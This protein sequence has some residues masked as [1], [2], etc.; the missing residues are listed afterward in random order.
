M[1]AHEGTPKKGSKTGAARKAISQALFLESFAKS[2]NVRLAAG[3]AGISRRTHYKWLSL[4]ESDYAVAFKDA[5]DEA[6]DVLESEACRR[7]VEGVEEPVGWYKGEPGGFVRRY[8]D[9]LLMFLLKARRPEMYR[10][11]FERTERDVPRITEIRR[12]I[13]YPRERR[14]SVDTGTAAVVSVTEGPAATDIES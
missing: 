4:S 6:I 13:I 7:A 5:E 8:S 9:N 11:R 3:A 12:V 10:E 2:G 1:G 14:P